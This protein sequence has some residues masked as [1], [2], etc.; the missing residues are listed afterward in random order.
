MTDHLTLPRMT[1]QEAL[2]IVSGHEDMIVNMKVREH[3]RDSS[4]P[5][6]TELLREDRVAE[7]TART[8]FACLVA[9]CVLWYVL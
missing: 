4:M 6:K 1:R 3:M 5:F 9:A 2:D 7:L 8:V